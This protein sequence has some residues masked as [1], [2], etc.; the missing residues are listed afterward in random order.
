MVVDRKVALLN[1]NNMQDRPNVEMMIHIE[2]KI[3][4]SFYDMALYSW[5]AHLKPNLPLLTSEFTPSTD[6]KFGMDNV[7]MTQA[8]LDGKQGAATAASLSAEKKA[9]L[10]NWTSIK[11]SKQV[12]CEVGDSP[13]TRFISGRK[14]TITDHLNAGVQ[15]DT[16]QTIDPPAED[17]EEEEFKPHCIHAEHEEVPVSKESRVVDGKAS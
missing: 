9:F 14:I 11:A 1:S 17:D 5:Y 2:G 16:K 13:Q 8:D 6:I 12:A 4:Q 15:P 7:Y 3:V 10:Q